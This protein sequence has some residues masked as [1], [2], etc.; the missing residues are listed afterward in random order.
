[1]LHIPLT[2]HV[3]LVSR[4]PKPFLEISRVTDELKINISETCYLH[5]QDQCRQ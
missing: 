2:V 3:S 4:A 1:M 5:Q